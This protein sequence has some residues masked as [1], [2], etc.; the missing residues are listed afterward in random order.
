MLKSEPS[1]IEPVFSERLWGSKSLAPLFSG[2]INLPEPIG[3]AWLTSV[4]C[5]IATGPFAGKTLGQAWGEMPADWRGTMFSEPSDFPLLAKFIF[6]TDKL[7]IQV[8]PDDA[9]AALM[10]K[11]PVAA[12]KPKCGT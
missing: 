6:P 1:R 12:A 8:H 9:Y 3:E 2:K 4:D 7:S 5:P 11:S 10:S